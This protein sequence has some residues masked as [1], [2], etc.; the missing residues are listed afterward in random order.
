M[1][2]KRSA[3]FPSTSDREATGENVMSDPRSRLFVLLAAVMSLGVSPLARAQGSLEKV[4]VSLHDGWFVQSSSNT[5][6]TGAQISTPGFSTVGW[7]PTSIP[8]T[9]VGAQVQNGIYPSPYVGQNSQQ[10]PTWPPAGQNF[11]NVAWPSGSP[12]SVHWWFLNQF[13]IPSTLAG[14]RIYLHFDGIN[15]RANL[16]VNGTQIAS[17]TQMVGTYV[18]YEYD[19]TNV[20]VIGGNNAVALQITGP[21][22]SNQELAITY[23]DWQL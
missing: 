7:L 10:I 1:L 14:Q 23:V 11:A 16:W 22:G 13:T 18:R 9:P 15:Y 4:A 20:A 19:I 17:N 5:T 6:A 2:R 21:N 12:Y 3:Q 8:A